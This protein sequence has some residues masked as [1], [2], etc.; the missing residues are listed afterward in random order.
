MDK[1]FWESKKI[2]LALIGAGVEGLLAFLI[3]LAA[4]FGIEIPVAVL[5]YVAGIF[6]VTIG[7]T[8]AQ[9]VVRLRKNGEQA[10]LPQTPLGSSPSMWDEWDD[11]IEWPQD[12]TTTTPHDTYTLSPDS[13]S[14]DI[15][16]AHGTTSNR[17]DLDGLEK[18]FAQQLGEAG[19]TLWVD[20]VEIVNPTR[21]YSK[22]TARANTYDLRN[23]PL[24]ERIDE[25]LRWNH[26]LI[27]LARN[28][29]R[30]FVKMA[31]PITISNPKELLAAI[32][33]SKGCGEFV[34]SYERFHVY[35]LWG[36]Y[37]QRDALMDA[38]TFSWSA[39]FGNARVTPWQ[40]G[41]A[42]KGGLL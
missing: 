18:A 1:K 30:T 7:G 36:L 12:Y 10:S 25:A 5:A 21:M 2:K 29:F 15:G 28:S 3:A 16:D 17:V 41:Q 32:R 24:H 33:A 38:P 23:I 6:G 26:K 4:E 20:G 40:L 22:F 9:D 35:E 39:K 27:V 42:A 34:G 19:E 8:A 37:Q 14:E 11:D 31:P 13:V